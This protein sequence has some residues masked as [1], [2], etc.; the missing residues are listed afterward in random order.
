MSP[1]SRA[2]PPAQPWTESPGIARLGDWVAAERRPLDRP[3][4]VGING[5]QG[6]GKSTLARTL[7]HYLNQAHGLHT[8]VLG[9]DD[10]YLTHR[11]RQRLARDVH[12]LL[13]TRGVPG[14]HDVAL[15][16]SLLERLSGL[17]SGDSLAVPRFFKSIDDR[18]PERDWPSLSGP[19]DV[20]LFEGWCVGTPAQTAAELTR[21]VNP[22][23]R[24]EDP[25]ARWRGWVNEQLA[26]VYPALFTRIDRL[27]YLQIPDFG[28]VLRWRRQQEAGNAREQ[29]Q[30]P[31][32]LMDAAALRR[33]VQHY[34]RLTRHA[35]A[36]L[37]SQADATVRIGA[38]HRILGMQLKD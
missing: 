37:P 32:R 25:D 27:V 14:T 19:L 6:S 18:A 15:G 16:V 3:L 30:Q 13:Q 34:E 24:D 17:E 5:A 35:M 38:R 11:E 33:F 28:C 21:P 12:P 22:L 26:N 36:T 7:A 9:L 8:A 4:I 2:Q 23:E 20:I 1:T 31:Q 10:L 29:T